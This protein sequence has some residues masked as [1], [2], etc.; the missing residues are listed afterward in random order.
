MRAV[1]QR[2]KQASVHVDGEL[3]SQIGPGILALIGICH[4]DTPEQMQVL[5]KK[6][7]G[8]RLWPDG[9]RIE[10]G[11]LTKTAEGARQWCASVMDLGGEIL[12]V[13]QFTLYAKT[14]KGT[15]P[16]FHRAMGG[17]SSKQFYEAFLARLGEQYTPERIK[18]GRFG[19]MMDVSLVNDV[20]DSFDKNL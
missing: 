19:A 18:D 7:L 10:E 6:M 16:D 11:R 12:C 13:S 17:E 20:I 15:K 3:V 2:V 1:L 8:T 4:D 14:A 9:T 5:V